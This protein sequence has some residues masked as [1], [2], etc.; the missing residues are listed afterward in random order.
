[1]RCVRS[2]SRYRQIKLSIIYSYFAV[3]AFAPI[4]SSRRDSIINRANITVKVASPSSFHLRYV[5]S[6]D[7]K[8]CIVFAPINCL[9]ALHSPL[10]QVFCFWNAGIKMCVC[11]ITR[12]SETFF[13]LHKKEQVLHRTVSKF[14]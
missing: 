2:L 13:L 6:E 7:T 8:L 4:N 14:P 1:M 12:I 9:T 11:C 10:F 3:R 5:K